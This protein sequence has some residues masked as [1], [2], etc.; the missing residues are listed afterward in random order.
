MIKMINLEVSIFILETEAS[1]QR[2]LSLQEGEALFSE[3]IGSS[4]EQVHLGRY[5]Q[6]VPY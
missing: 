2:R 1:S 6:L 5:A 3:G 4:D